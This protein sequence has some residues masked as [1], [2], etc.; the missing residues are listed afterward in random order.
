MSESSSAAELVSA[1]VRPPRLVAIGRRTT[2]GEIVEII[3]HLELWPWR[4]V[5]RGVRASDATRPLDLGH[6]A[7]PADPD[8]TTTGVVTAEVVTGDGAW[9]RDLQRLTSWEISDDVGT[10][11][12]SSSASGGGV[13]TMWEDFSIQFEPAVPANA[14]T[15]RIITADSEEIVLA[16]DSDP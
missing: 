2:S 4:V 15:L 3:S 8:T 13:G 9:A 14:S 1:F 7:Q 6:R 12:R 16:L 10:E 5:L 11:Y